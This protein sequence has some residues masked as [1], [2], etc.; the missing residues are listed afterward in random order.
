MFALLS[1][2][3]VFHFRGLKELKQPKAE[4]AK[5]IKQHGGKGTL[6]LH[7]RFSCPTSNSNS[8][9]PVDD[10][11]RSKTTYLV[12]PYL[13]SC[14]QCRI[15]LGKPVVKEQVCFALLESQRACLQWIQA[16]ID[17]GVCLKDGEHVWSQE[18]AG[19]LLSCFDRLTD[20]VADTQTRPRK[21]KRAK[22]GSSKKASS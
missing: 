2:D 20:N 19:D 18:E 8:R 12:A 14:L 9:H 21:V 17:A 6:H 4:L 5:L 13:T 11:M 3:A 7:A 10:V 1:S 22:S 15:G 16:S